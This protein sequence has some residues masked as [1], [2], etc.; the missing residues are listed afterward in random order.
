MRFRFVF[1]SIFL[2][3]FIYLLTLPLVLGQTRSFTHVIS[4]SEDWHDVYSTVHYANLLRKGSDFLV[5]TRHSTLLLPSLS[6]ANVVRIVTSPS[7]AYAL[8]YNSTLEDN[9]FTVED[10]VFVRNANLEL[11][12]ELTDVRDFVIVGSSYGYSGVA[13][14]P[15]AV[16]KQAWVF[17]A[18]RQNI[19]D[20]STFLERRNPRS[21]LIY[22]PVDREVRTELAQFNPEILDKGDRFKDNI[23]IV[24]KYLALHPTTQVALT[25]GEFIEKG[26]MSGFDPILFT[27]KENVPDQIGAYL[28]TSNFGVGVLVG[29]DLVGAATN[30][31]RSTGISV[32]AKFAQGARNPTGPIAAV[33]GLDLFY[34]TTPIM[35]L[36]LHSAKYNR[37]TSQLEITYKS[38]SNVPIYFKGTLTPTDERGVQPRFGDIEAIFIAPN[39]FKTISYPN[40]RLEG[41]EL[42]VQVFTL[43][44]DAPSSL[45]RILDQRIDIS[46][47]NVIDSCEVEVTRV[48]YSKPKEVFLIYVD[49]IGDVDCWVNVELRDVIVDGRAKTLGSSGSTLIDAGD[50]G[51][52]F[53]DERMSEGDLAD[54]PLVDL[55]AYYGEREDSLIKLFQG[56]FELGIQSIT[57]LTIALIVAIVLLLFLILLLWRRRKKEDDF[58]W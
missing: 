49:N 22:G 38:E 9:G 34:L 18:N 57:P 58:S 20:I 29:S 46:Q 30:I 1:L 55:T 10:E 19:A 56:K 6:R 43:Y 50:S 36:A 5:S 48:L 47:V 26:L 31:R 27:G 42:S 15:Y 17:F 4:N 24:K 11:V 13:V 32:I 35:K 51:K 54:N 52:V 16:K 23:E 28:K 44:G 12:E 21:V 45:E 25:N 14:A 53:I 3:V 33:E 7:K 37:A 39:D 40:V 41:D 8:N 2:A